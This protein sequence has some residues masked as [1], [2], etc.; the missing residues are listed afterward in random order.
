MLHATGVGCTCTTAGALGRRTVTQRRMALSVI[1]LTFDRRS[2]V[3]NF[4]EHSRGLSMSAVNGFR[5]WCTRSTGM[6]GLRG[7]KTRPI[8]SWRATGSLTGQPNEASEGRH[9]GPVNRQLIFGQLS[10]RSAQDSTGAAAAQNVPTAGCYPDRPHAPS[11]WPCAIRRKLP[12]ESCPAPS[13]PD[14]RS[15]EQARPGS[16]REIV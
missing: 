14:H 8:L 12:L 6:R 1:A 2:Q 3:R 4:G 16:A 11:Q 7:R 13:P 5:F 15:T 9:P 10:E